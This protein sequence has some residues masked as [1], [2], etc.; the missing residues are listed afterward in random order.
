VK[1]K[2]QLV[3][4]LLPLR[5]LQVLVEAH[6]EQLFEFFLAQVVL[7]LVGLHTFGELVLKFLIG[8]FGRLGVEESFER[9]LMGVTYLITFLNF[10]VN[11]RVL[12]CVKAFKEGLE[13]RVFNTLRDTN[14]RGTLRLIL[15]LLMFKGNSHASILLVVAGGVALPNVHL[16]VHLKDVG[17]FGF[18]HGT[19]Q[20]TLRDLSSQHFSFWVFSDIPEAVHHLFLLS[21]VGLLISRTGWLHI[22][23]RALKVT[24][25]IFLYVAFH[26]LWEVNLSVRLHFVVLEVL[27]IVG[28]RN[29]LEHVGLRTL[30]HVDILTHV[31]DEAVRI[32]H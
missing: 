12:F 3:S 14:D 4:G 17:V 30:P 31:E 25:K 11:D 19:P 15:C 23:C 10:L 29:P 27:C 22:S 20:G 18:E 6:F 16:V 28:C 8:E 13:Q 7:F 32:V 2:R 24:P 9:S 26:G 1:A 5:D 21:R